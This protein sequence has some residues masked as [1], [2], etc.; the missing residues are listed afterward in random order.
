MDYFGMM[1]GW[2]DACI[3]LEVGIVGARNR[4]GE[5]ELK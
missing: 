3:K 1:D 5:V 4:K 2:M